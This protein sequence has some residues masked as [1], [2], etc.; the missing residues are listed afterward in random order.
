MQEP[1]LKRPKAATEDGV[2][3]E[4]ASAITDLRGR[5]PLETISRA[6]RVEVNRAPHVTAD[7]KS[8]SWH[9]TVHDDSDTEYSV[10]IDLEASRTAGRLGGAG[11]IGGPG[12]T[13]VTGVTGG[14]GGIGGAGGGRAGGASRTQSDLVAGVY[15]ECAFFSD[16]GAC[17]HGFAAVEYLENDLRL[18]DDRQRQALAAFIE[19]RGARAGDWYLSR[20]IGAVRERNERVSE[21]ESRLQWRIALTSDDPERALGLRIYEQKRMRRGSQWSRGR[22]LDWTSQGFLEL[23]SRSVQ[24]L[25]AGGLLRSVAPRF[26]ANE[27]Q[28]VELLPALIGHPNVVWDDE[29]R[30][31]VHVLH[32]PLRITV[33]AVEKDQYEVVLRMGQTAIYPPPPG[34]EFTTTVSG[35]QWDARRVVL[36]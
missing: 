25:R 8:I 28:L 14:P 19:A 17:A 16:S 21:A 3:A 30:A 29:L 2:P 36:A 4:I 27:R 35:Q 32:R 6:R 10:E 26:D 34:R 11:G 18:L 9:F 15:C 20:L 13:G 12:V 23:C 22:Q 33:A 24:D 5:F 1:K 7:E 31:A